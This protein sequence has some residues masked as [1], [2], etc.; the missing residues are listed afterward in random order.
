MGTP[1]D[2]SSTLFNLLLHNPIFLRWTT[3]RPGLF[4][5]PQG[6][7]DVTYSWMSYVEN[8]KTV[9]LGPDSRISNMR[10]SG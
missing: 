2:G 10:R 9:S 3:R 5:K 8:G 6:P 1:T 4:T 7:R